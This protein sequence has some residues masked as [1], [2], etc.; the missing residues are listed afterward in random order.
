MPVRTQIERI[1]NKLATLKDS[2][3]PEARSDSYVLD[4]MDSVVDQLTSLEVYV[5]EFNYDRVPEILSK[6]LTRSNGERA[7]REVRGDV[8]ELGQEIC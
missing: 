4:T 6:T 2:L 7:F 3:A 5:E 8:L 1:I